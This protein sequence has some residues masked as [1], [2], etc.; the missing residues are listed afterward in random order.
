MKTMQSTKEI[1]SSTQ[2]SQESQGE[3]PDNHATEAPVT[4]SGSVSTSS[5]DGKKVS[6]QDIELVQNLIERCLQ[7]YMNRDEVVKTLL[8]RARIDPGFTTLVWQKLEEENADFF[9]AYYIRL[10]LKRQIILFNHLLEHQYHLMKYPVAPKVPL[11]PIQNG[12]HP[13]PVNNLPMGYPILQQPPIP[14]AGQPHVDP[15][16]HGISSCHVVNGVPAPSNFHHIQMNSGNDMVMESGAADVAPIIPPNGTMSEMPVSPTSVASSGHF[17]FTA[18]EI[19]GMGVDSSAL[20]TTFASDVASSVGLQLAPDGG[21]GNSRDSLR[22]LDQIQWNFSLSDLTADLSN[23]GGNL[24]AL[25][26]YPGSPFLPSDSEI[27]LDSPEQED[28]VEEFFVDSVPGP[29]SSQS[30]EENPRER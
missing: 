26:N 8:T 29:S 3:Q 30:D 21:A 4:D 22:S 18:P 9:R 27:L 20:D 2:V 13:I 7:L 25:G 24:G 17:P 16:G 1:Q 23:L 11:A 15:M 14:A 12:I 5:N 10:K 6:R 28:I 19:S